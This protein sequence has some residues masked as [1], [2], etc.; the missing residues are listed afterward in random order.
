MFL[1]IK[2]VGAFKR[3]L[4]RELGEEVDAL[5]LA[6]NPSYA[7]YYCRLALKHKRAS[8]ELQAIAQRIRVRMK[9]AT[10]IDPET[11]LPFNYEGSP[12]LH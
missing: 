9:R 3:L 12:A 6:N 10:V 2:T 8:I 7:R 4:E 1:D 11:L 5:S